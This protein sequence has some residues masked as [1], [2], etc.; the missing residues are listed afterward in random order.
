[1]CCRFQSVS[2]GA[3]A[4]R[5]DIGMILLADDRRDA[6]GHREPIGCR[7]IVDRSDGS[8]CVVGNGITVGGCG[9]DVVGSV[10]VGALGIGSAM[11]AGGIVECGQH[12]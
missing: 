3:Y 4:G 11:G 5:I 6:Y 7:S 10:V 8:R 2:C 12:I 9:P 1:M